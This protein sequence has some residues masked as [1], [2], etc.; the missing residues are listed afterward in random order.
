MANDARRPLSRVAA[1]IGVPQTTLHQRVRRL[2]EAGVIVGSRLLIDWEKV[3]LPVLAIVSLEVTAPGPFEDAAR[4]LTDIP[5]VQSCYSITG[6]F[7]LMLVVRAQSSD[8]LGEV[9]EMVRA[10]VPGHS[11]TLV[12]LSTFWDGRVPPPAGEAPPGNGGSG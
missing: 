1:E 12:V 6:E 8:H 9:L 5:Y 7:D 2:E 10:A 3:G 4:A 11:R